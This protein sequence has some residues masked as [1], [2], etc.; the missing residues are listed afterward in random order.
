MSSLFPA[1]GRARRAA[2][3]VASMLPVALLGACASAGSS[4]GADSTASADSSAS[5]SPAATEAASRTARI[6]VT[7]DGGIKILDALNLEELGDIPLDGFNRLNPAG[8][9]RHLMVSTT[10][11]FQ[12]L[13][14]GT[15]AEAH[16]DHAHYWTADPVLTDV[17]YPADEPGHVVVHEGRTALFDDG[18]G[19]VSVVDAAHVADGDV[20]RA[21]SLPAAHHGVAVELADDTLVVTDGTEDERSGVRVL[22]AQGE[23]IAASD[24]CPGVHGEA[25]AADEAIVLGCEDGALLVRDGEISKVKAPDGYGRI[26]NQAGTEASPVVLGDYKVDPD[27]ELERPEQVSLIDTRSGD[28]TLVDLPSSY[29]FRSL[30]RGD[31]GEALVLGTDGQV[32]VI[33]PE[34]GKVVKSIEVIDAWEEPAEWQS[35][36]PAILALDGSVYVTDPANEA[37][38]A[39]DVE[40]GEVWKEAG[41]GVVPNEIAGVMGEVAEHGHGPD[42]GHDDGDHEDGEGH[43]HDE[44]D[45]EGDDGHGDGDGH[46][47]E[48][49]DEHDHGGDDH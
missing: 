43:D 14:L 15:W 46:D 33:D 39:V 47:D 11:G 31:D 38:H 48:H 23:E 8:D 36:R 34:K 25:M 19:Q 24:D 28:L 18:T 2:V 32:H 30:A 7:Y 29:T 4:G 41:L 1:R 5:E 42:G 45:G 16:G 40:T 22:D 49:G 20:A 44:H 9:E 21:E 17:V 27:A 26:G 35:P 12:V 13:D 37:I 6:A 3:L 10:G